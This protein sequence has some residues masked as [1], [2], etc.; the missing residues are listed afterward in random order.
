MKN[1]MERILI[2][3][4][5]SI[6]TITSDIEIDLLIKLLTKKKEEIIKKYPE[7]VDNRIEVLVEYDTEYRECELSIGYIRKEND[8]EYRCRMRADENMKRE[9]NAALRRAIDSN[10]EEAVAYLKSIGVI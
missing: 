4:E 6:C 8:T 5:E 7:A 9:K 3:A 10:K 1:N 2:C